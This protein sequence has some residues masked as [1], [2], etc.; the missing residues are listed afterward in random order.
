MTTKERS[1]WVW[2][3]AG[4]FLAGLVMLNIINQV[5]LWMEVY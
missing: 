4:F 5:Y 2:K 3:N 1:E